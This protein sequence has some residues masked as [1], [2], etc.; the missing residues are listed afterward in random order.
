[1]ATNATTAQAGNDPL[2]QAGNMPNLAALKQEFEYARDQGPCKLGDIAL[3]ESIYMGQRGQVRRSQQLVVLGMI[4][5]DATQIKW[6]LQK[7]SNGKK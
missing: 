3:A 6:A 2:A 5:N 7:E 4:D 1:M